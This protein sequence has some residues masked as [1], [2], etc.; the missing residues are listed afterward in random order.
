MLTIRRFILVAVAALLA[1]SSCISPDDIEV[2]SFDDV[3]IRSTSEVDLLFTVENKSGR[4][5]KVSDIVV[6]IDRK[7]SELVKGIS[8]KDV[9]IPKRSNGRVTVPLRVKLAGFEFLTLMFEGEETLKN[10][11][12]EL[13]V[14]GAATV[15]IG[16]RSRRFNIEETDIKPMI[17]QLTKM[18]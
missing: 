16:R 4:N 18:L 1:M 8:S 2:V 12:S 10:L 5:I 9:T 3:V 7:G 13:S 15:S 11:E 14:K 17:E 6:T